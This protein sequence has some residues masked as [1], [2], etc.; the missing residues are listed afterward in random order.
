MKK[1]ALILILSIVFIAPSV[2]AYRYQQKDIR[3][4]PYTA[5]KQAKS[6]GLKP[7]WKENSVKTQIERMK[8]KDAK[9]FETALTQKYQNPAQYQSYLYEIRDGR[10]AVEKAKTIARLQ[11]YNTI[12]KNWSDLKKTILNSHAASEWKEFSVY[13]KGKLQN[14]HYVPGKK[15][16]SQFV[17][18]VD[19]WGLVKV[20]RNLRKADVKL[21][22]GARLD[23]NQTPPGAAAI[24]ISSDSIARSDFDRTKKLKGDYPEKL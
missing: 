19:D 7:H 10:K 16:N 15:A 13:L 11:I 5:M 12:R 9:A 17:F 3:I 14:L 2:Y 21:L 4:N 20:Q 6:L 23:A 18:L 24:Q 8:K 22:V 1:R